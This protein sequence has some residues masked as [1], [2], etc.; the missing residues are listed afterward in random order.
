MVTTH[1]S[2]IFEHLLRLRVH[3]SRR[4][5]EHEEMGTNARIDA[6]QARVLSVK[7][8]RL[9]LWTRRRREIAQ[10]YNRAFEGIAGLRTP[11]GSD[12]RAGSLF[13][14]VFHQY[15]LRVEGEG[16]RDRLRGALTDR[17]IGSEVYYPIPLHRQKAFS[18]NPTIHG[19]LA[20]S[21]GLSREVLSLPVF[22]ELREE[23]QARVIDA[24]R[25]FFSP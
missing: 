14:H 12:E 18:G 20:V 7:L 4:R 6:L 11:E 3:G 10:A 5:Y 1:D 8:P 25:E 2:A 21:E 24:V 19:P 13:E 22:P 23:E 9:A 17:A 16:V 15:T